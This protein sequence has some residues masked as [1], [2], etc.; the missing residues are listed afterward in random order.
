MPGASVSIQSV[1]TNELRTAT[2]GNDG[3]Y[4][5]P[6][7]TVGHYNVKIEKNGFKTAT[8]QNLT[9]DVAQ[10]LV[11]NVALTV[12]ESTQEVV[13][14]GEATQ[15][16]TTTSSLAHVVDEQQVADLPLN[17]RSFVDLSLMQTGI[18]RIRAI[19]ITRAIAAPGTTATEHQRAPTPTR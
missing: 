4:R 14:T 8:Q 17:G 9:L 6:G 3:A 19:P 5:V 15:I 18:N 2:T 7:L 1:E 10:E 12:G 16:N 11:V 13:V